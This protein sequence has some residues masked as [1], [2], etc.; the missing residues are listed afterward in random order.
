MKVHRN[1]KP[2]FEIEAPERPIFFEAFCILVK[3]LT[4]EKKGPG[5]R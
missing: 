1:C 2:F 5:N 3:N 4:N